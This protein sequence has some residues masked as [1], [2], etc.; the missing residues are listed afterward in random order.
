M[1]LKPNKLG[2]TTDKSY[3]VISFLNGIRKEFKKVVADMLSQWY[4]IDNVLYPIQIESRRK[5]ITIDAVA[6]VI[7]RV[8]E[9]CS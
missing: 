6:R 3:R 2:N 9:A 5:R 8:Q 1:L 4:D 7:S